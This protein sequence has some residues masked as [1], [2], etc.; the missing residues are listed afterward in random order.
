M[1]GRGTS[2]GHCRGYP[3]GALVH[4]LA[5]PGTLSCTYAGRY[6]SAHCTQRFSQH[7]RRGDCRFRVRG[8]S[9]GAFW[10]KTHQSVMAL[11][12]PSQTT[13]HRLQTT[14]AG[15]RD[16]NGARKFY[17]SQG[18][19]QGRPGQGGEARRGKQEVAWVVPSSLQRHRRPSPS[20]PCDWTA[21]CPHLRHQCIRGGRPAGGATGPVSLVWHLRTVT[22]SNHWVLRG[23]PTPDALLM[24]SSV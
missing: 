3:L 8:F 20:A 13:A 21:Q 5:G 1:A 9:P 2:A 14:M 10:A 23:P 19:G 7:Q 6:L 11:R 24:P 15:V 4:P 18:G 12:T 16:L 22:P 17:I